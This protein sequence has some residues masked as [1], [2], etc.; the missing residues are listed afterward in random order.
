[1]AIGASQTFVYDG[2]ASVTSPVRLAS[3]WTTI[4]D[5]NATLGVRAVDAS[6][7]TDPDTQIKSAKRMMLRESRANILRVRVVY[8]SDQTVTTDPIVVLFGQMTDSEVWQPL[9]NMA[10]SPAERVTI[11]HNN[12]Q[13]LNI[14]GFRYT[15][16]D[17]LTVAWNVEGY[18]RLVL[19]VEVALALSGGT[20]PDEPYVQGRLYSSL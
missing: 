16:P 20:N 12:N 18:E 1:M 10:A 6:T 15:N 19:G 8:D 9:Q 3:R 11:A 2:S 14:G 17:R 5:A 13:D 7:I 4:I